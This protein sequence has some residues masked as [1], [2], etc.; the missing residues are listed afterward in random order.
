M[1]N[2]LSD[3]PAYVLPDMWEV[4]QRTLTFQG[5]YPEGFL[6]TLVARDSLV[7]TT[8]RNHLLESQGQRGDPRFPSWSIGSGQSLIADTTNPL[9]CALYDLITAP[10]LSLPLDKLR[11]CCGL[12]DLSTSGLAPRRAFILTVNDP[13]SNTLTWTSD[14]FTQSCFGGQIRRAVSSWDFMTAFDPVFLPLVDE[15]ENGSGLLLRNL[16]TVT[17]SSTYSSINTLFTA[18]S[19]PTSD[20]PFAVVGGTSLSDTTYIPP[21]QAQRLVPRG[22]DLSAGALSCGDSVSSFLA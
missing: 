10:M 9:L 8:E 4:G 16:G 21:A 1:T 22:L 12:F 2:F 5:D 7:P 3:P 6:P 18:L 11:L 19:L 13:V 17:Y 15:S 14:S 20:E